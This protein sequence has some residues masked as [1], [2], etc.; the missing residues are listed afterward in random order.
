[1]TGILLLSKMEF[2]RA[3]QVFFEEQMKN[4]VKT[5]KN[6]WF[7]GNGDLLKQWGLKGLRLERSEPQRRELKSLFLSF[8]S[9]GHL[10]DSGKET[11]L[12]IQT[13]SENQEDGWQN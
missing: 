7:K 2:W 8:F 5:Y 1:M 13:G 12:G 4:Q 11:M 10:T 9:C 3:V 6:N